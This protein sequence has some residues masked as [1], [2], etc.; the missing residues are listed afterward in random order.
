MKKRMHIFAF[1]RVQRVWYR[2]NTK[3][4]ADALGVFGWVKNLKDKR[5]EAVA[6][7]EEEEVLRLVEWMK[8]GPIYAKVTKLE[9]FEEEYEGEFEGFE[10]IY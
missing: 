4:K 1:G 5:V 9:F 8:K 10:I 3:K 7:G 2:E 6:Q